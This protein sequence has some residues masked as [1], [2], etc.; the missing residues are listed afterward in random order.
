MGKLADSLKERLAF[1]V[2]DSA[3]YFNEHH[4]GRAV[5]VEGDAALNLVGDVR[6]YL[7][8][9]AAVNPVSLILKHGIEN[10]TGGTNAV[11]AQVFINEALIVTQIKIGLR[12]VIGDKNLAVLNG[13]HCAGV[14]IKIRVELHGFYFQSSGFEQSAQ[15]CRS[16]ALAQTGDN[17]AGYK[18]KLSF[19][20]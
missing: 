17:A 11:N 1:D 6:D 9:F 5:V 2:A 10:A 12:T 8:R 3:A 15:R 20:F 4:I 14:D 13:I 7:H 18:N 16:Y 19:H